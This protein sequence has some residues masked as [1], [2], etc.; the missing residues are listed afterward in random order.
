LA[1]VFAFQVTS[2]D[3]KNYGHDLHGATLI[4]LPPE[5]PLW[6]SAQRFDVVLLDGPKEYYALK[7]AYEHYE[8]YGKIVALHDIAGLRACQD[9]KR[10]WGEQ[11]RYKNGR[12][13]R[14][15]HEVIADGPAAA[16]LGWCR[17]G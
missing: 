10:F 5:C 7:E 1:N 2:V 9:V 12:K 6:V 3:I 13:K 15:F 11:S 17:R 4:V 14:G 8:S 16:G